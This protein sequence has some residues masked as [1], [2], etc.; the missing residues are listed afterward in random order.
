MMQEFLHSQLF[1]VAAGVV[2]VLFLARIVWRMFAPRRID[3][4]HMRVRCPVCG[5]TGTVGKHMRK[6]SRCG[7][8][9]LE[10]LR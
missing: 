8:T 4:L 6:C 7:N 10:P 9:T 2:A 5:W 1:R 3:S